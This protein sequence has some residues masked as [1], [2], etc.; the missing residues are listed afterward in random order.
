MISIAAS[1]SEI[2]IY[3]LRTELVAVHDEIIRFANSPEISLLIPADCSADAGPHG[4]ALSELVIRKSDNV[5]H[6]SFSKGNLIVTG[7]CNNLIILSSYFWSA[8]TPF[9]NESSSLMH[10]VEIE[11]IAK[12]SI[13]LAICV[14]L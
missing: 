11:H 14:R 5:I 4:T 9:G 10:S 6:V 2:L 7:S 3:G 1:E 12:D 8:Q 13:P